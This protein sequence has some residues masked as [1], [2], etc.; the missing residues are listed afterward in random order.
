MIVKNKKIIVEM[1]TVATNNGILDIQKAF[2]LLHCSVNAFYCSVLIRRLLLIIV[3][4]SL[5]D[6][7]LALIGVK[8]SFNSQ[9]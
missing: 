7:I 2:T 3:C 1:N 4:I 8:L 5:I 9:K 6:G